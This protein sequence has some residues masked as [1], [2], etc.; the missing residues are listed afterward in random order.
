MEKCNHPNCV[1]G[2]MHEELFPGVIVMKRCDYCIHDEQ[3]IKEHIA[4]IRAQRKELEK[5]FSEVLYG[6]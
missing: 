5:Q 2:V 6:N 4:E 1:N 3:S